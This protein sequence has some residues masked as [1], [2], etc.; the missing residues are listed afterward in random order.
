MMSSANPSRIAACRSY[1]ADIVFTDDVHRAFEIA[2]DI[3]EQEGRYLVHPYEGPEV[4]TGTGTIGVEICED[5]DAFDAVLVSIGGG[6]LMGGIANAIKQLRPECELIGIEPE[7][8]DS[9]HRSFAAGEPRGIDEVRT[10]ADSLGAPFA[11][12]YSFG[13][14]RDNV[15]RLAVVDDLELRKSMGLLFRKMKIA[16]EPAC[17]ATTAALAGPLRESLAGKT[18][19][20][21]MCGSN[22]D[23]ATFAEQA[24]FGD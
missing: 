17:A 14:C 7:G 13:L 23:W 22:I 2:E 1:G 20:L 24:V 21:V 15:D 10:I 4:A 19:V 3:G 8:A 18:V 9:M 12:P 5:C 11:M 16:V 6:G